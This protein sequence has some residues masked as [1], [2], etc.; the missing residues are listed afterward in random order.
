MQI[1]PICG[2]TR[3]EQDAQ[4][5]LVSAQ[6]RLLHTQWKQRND[7]NEPA[8]GLAVTDEYRVHFALWL[9][10]DDSSKKSHA[11]ALARAVREA[12][13]DYKQVAKALT[14]ANRA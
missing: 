9:Y 8:P 6:W 1:C 2:I 5:E 14:H 3:E 11:A 13:A 10:Q 12:R 4:Q 7:P